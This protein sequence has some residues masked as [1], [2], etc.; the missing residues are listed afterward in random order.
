MHPAVVPIERLLYHALVSAL[1]SAG[2][3]EAWSVQSSDNEHILEIACGD[4]CTGLGS[5]QRSGHQ[6]QQCDQKTG[7]KGKEGQAREKA[8]GITR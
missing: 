7:L 6:G 1:K 8:N 4:N 3:R 2:S 5:W